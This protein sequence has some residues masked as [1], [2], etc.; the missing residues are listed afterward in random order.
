MIVGYLGYWCTD[1]TV[2]KVFCGGATIVL[3]EVQATLDQAG[4]QTLTLDTRLY[5]CLLGLQRAAT[6]AALPQAERHP[7]LEVRCR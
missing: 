5:S 4:A 1:V 2:K 6:V 7:A 3:P